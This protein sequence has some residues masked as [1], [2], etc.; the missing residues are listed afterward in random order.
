MY[1]L[2]ILN[3]CPIKLRSHFTILSLF[4]SYIFDLSLHQQTAS[5]DVH[6]QAPTNPANTRYQQR[7]G[8]KDNGHGRRHTHRLRPTS[9]GRLQA[10]WTRP[11]VKPCT[12]GTRTARS[13]ENI[14]TRGRRAGKSRVE[15]TKVTAKAVR[16]RR[17]PPELRVTTMAARPQRPCP[18][19]W[20][21]HRMA[22]GAGQWSLPL[23][24]AIWLWTE[25]STRSACFPQP[26]ANQWAPA[27]QRSR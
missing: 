11:T 21:C 26:L 6:T 15:K 8:Q 25:L 2:M 14:A 10:Q 13:M 23:F 24:C 7:V 3:F 17:R 22:A 27:K 16:P 9:S 18:P 20:Q 4:K 12:W 5:I 1:S 19:M